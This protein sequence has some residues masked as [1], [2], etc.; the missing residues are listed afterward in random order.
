[1]KTT[2]TSHWIGG[3]PSTN[4]SG[5]SG[6]P[7][8][9]RSSDGTFEYIRFVGSWWSSSQDNTS[10]AWLRLLIFNDGSVDRYSGEKTAGFS[11][12]CISD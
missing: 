5:F 9:G 10:N 4:S 8:G 3:F 2:G 12:R 7:G 11:V 6:L 1:M